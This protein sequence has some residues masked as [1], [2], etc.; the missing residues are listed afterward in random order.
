[1]M[2]CAAIHVINFFL[3]R[4]E[5]FHVCFQSKLAMMSG[6]FK[7]VLEVRTEVNVESL[8]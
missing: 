1:M 3:Q 2:Y 8:F 7:S 6:N 4:C 5:P